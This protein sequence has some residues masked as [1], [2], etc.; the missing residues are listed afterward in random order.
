M[1]KNFSSS[2]SQSGH[3]IELCQRA[4]SCD[5]GPSQAC[6]I[7]AITMCNTLDQSHTA[8]SP[9]LPRERSITESRQKGFQVSPAQSV[10]I[11]FRP[12]QCAQQPLFVTM[13]EVQALDGALSI[14]PGFAQAFQIPCPMSGIVQR[15]KKFQITAIA[16]KQKNKRTGASLQSRALQPKP[17]Y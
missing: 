7:V 2:S 14:P 13:E 4:G 5:G 6:Q 9:K 3:D 11:E 16:A 17:G 12:L 15:G 1:A 10:D 8:Q